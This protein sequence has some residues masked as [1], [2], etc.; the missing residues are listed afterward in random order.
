MIITGAGGAIG[1][2]TAHALAQA[3]ANVVVS[4]LNL[5]NAEAVAAAV[6]QATGRETLA[7]G[8]TSPMRPSIRRW[9]TRH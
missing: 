4:D 2:A 1:G 8:P 6:Q 5:A 3:G 9:W 7:V